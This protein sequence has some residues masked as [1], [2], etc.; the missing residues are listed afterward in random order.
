MTNKNQQPDDVT[1]L[2]FVII[3]AH[4]GFDV[5]GVTTKDNLYGD[6]GMDSLDQ[7]EI[8][9]DLEHELKIVLPDTRGQELL[10]GT[11]GDLIE[12]VR[13]E[14]EKSNVNYVYKKFVPNSKVVMMQH[15]EPVVSFPDWVRK[16]F[17][18]LVR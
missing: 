8:L 7:I 5:A 1:K 10:Y 14:L 2:V 16:K 4:M 17:D 6:L 9:M 11:V 15:P 18:N 13:F 3:R 12:F